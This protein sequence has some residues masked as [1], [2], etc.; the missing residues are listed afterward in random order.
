MTSRDRGYPNS[1]IRKGGCANLI[2]TG[3]EAGEEILKIEL[4][5]FVTRDQRLED[6]QSIYRE[7]ILR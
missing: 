5:S 7:N 2:L 3:E 4:I 1:D 6:L